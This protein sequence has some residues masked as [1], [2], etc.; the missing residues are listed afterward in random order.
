M[1]NVIVIAFV[2]L[3]VECEA[4]FIVKLIRCQNFKRS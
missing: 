3:E 1:E 4:R 2:T